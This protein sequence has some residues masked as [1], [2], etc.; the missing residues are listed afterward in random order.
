MNYTCTINYKLRKLLYI[1]CKS[2]GT[3]YIVILCDNRKLKW[4]SVY[5]RAEGLA[6]EIKE[7][8]GQLADYN[9]VRK[10]LFHLKLYF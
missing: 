6:A 10:S 3:L 5:H 2:N 1:Y 7:L 4:I 9:T 8:Q